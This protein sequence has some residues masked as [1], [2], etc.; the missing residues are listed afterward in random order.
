MIYESSSSKTTGRLRNILFGDFLTKI[1][2]PHIK[3]NI[4]PPHFLEGG[5]LTLGSDTTHVFMPEILCQLSES[6]S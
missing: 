6:Y 3:E 2:D 1:F 4:D 5:G